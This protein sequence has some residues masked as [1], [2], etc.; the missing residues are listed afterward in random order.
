[1]RSRPTLVA[2]LLALTA[3]AHAQ[4]DRPTPLADAR[5]GFVTKVTPI[6]APDHR[7]APPEKPPYKNIKLVKYPAPKGDTWA[8]I[9]TPAAKKQD[10]ANQPSAPDAPRPAIVWI[11]GGDCNEIGDFVWQ[12]QG[13]EN[14][15]S[16]SAFHT[17]G[18]VTM[19]PSLRG[20]HDNPGKRE[21]FLGEVDDII[22]AADFLAKQPGVDPKRIYLGGHSTGGTMA[23]LVAASTPRFRAVFSYGPIGNTAKYGDELTGVSLP[24]A[25]LDPE[26][27]LRSPN[28][29]LDGITS[30][31]FIMEGAVGVSN[32]DELRAMAK[33]TSNPRIQMFVYK[34]RDHFSILAPSTGWVARQI[35]ADTGEE[36]SIA[37]K[38]KAITR[39]SHKG[40]PKATKPDDPKPE[41]KDDNK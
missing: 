15:Q 10:A 32:Q 24:M 12:K 21:A 5:R 13:P 29:W 7:P 16:A 26:V 8:Y 36:C 22:A 4:P 38:G 28:H 14:D 23:L 2:A 41:S 19:F 31:T 3:A 1:M 20:G 27:K 11:T 34:E 30:P 18:V 35:L 17:A 25:D 40:T 39:V 9:V 37:I 33:R 6:V